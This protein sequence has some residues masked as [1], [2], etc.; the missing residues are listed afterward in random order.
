MSLTSFL[1]FPPIRQQFKETFQIP[2]INLNAQLLAPPNT[3]NYSFVGT[4]FDYLLRF[5]IKQISPESI[6]SEWIAEGSVDRIKI[7]SGKYVLVDGNTEPFDPN[8]EISE[9]FPDAKSVSRYEPSEEWKRAIKPAEKIISGAKNQYEKFIQTGELE[10]E[11]IE[12]TLK[13]AQLDLVFRAEIIPTYNKIS[14]QDIDDLRNLFDVA[15]RSDIFKKNQKTYLNP[16][17]GKGSKLVGGADADLIIGDTLIDIKV[18]KDLKFKRD[19]YNQIIGYYVLSTVENKPTKIKNVGI[20]FA[21]HGV[22]HT[23]PIK[24]IGRRDDFED[25][26]VWFEAHAE[27]IKEKITI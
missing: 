14:K 17:F 4:A 27:K 21:R 26:L 1:K 3:K 9:Q 12:T 5:Y 8:K 13:L 16:K 2:K 6:D 11:L 7:L 24:E 25:V 10:D 20:Y 23:I 18:T 15:V 22:L 19:W